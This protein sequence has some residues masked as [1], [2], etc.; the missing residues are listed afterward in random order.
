MPLGRS[1]DDARFSFSVC[2]IK[3][4]HFFLDRPGPCVFQFEGGGRV[5]GVVGARG[6]LGPRDAACGSN[7]VRSGERDQHLTSGSGC[8]QRWGNQQIE[9]KELEENL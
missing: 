1:V 9:R 2:Q 6:K 8:F 3:F 5:H 7:D 4:V